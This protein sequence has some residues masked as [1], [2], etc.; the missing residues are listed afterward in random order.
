[1][2]DCLRMIDPQVLINQEKSVS[3]YSLNMEPFPPVIDGQFLLEDPVIMLENKVFKKCPVII[4]T[5][6]NEGLAAMMEYLPELGLQE[7]LFELD[8]NQLDSGMSRMFLSFSPSLINL[9]K[10]QYG[11][12]NDEDSSKAA[13]VKRFFGL[14]SALADKQII[15]HVDKLAKIY[16]EEA[17]KVICNAHNYI[18]GLN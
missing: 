2:V 10:F 18:T 9:V 13:K 17:N 14:Q 1:M 8:A 12:L 3:N 16:S 4:G 15:C 6:A 7:N 5:N 11:I